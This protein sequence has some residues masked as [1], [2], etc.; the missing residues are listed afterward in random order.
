MRKEQPD[1][2]PMKSARCPECDSSRLMYTSG[3]LTC[4]NCGHVIGK[5]FNKYGA[6]KTE[7]KG[8]KYDSKYEASVAAELDLR[9]RAGDIKDFE[10]QYRVE[11][12]V[13]R[14]NGSVAFIVRHKVDFRV[15]N[16]DGSYELIEAKGVETTDY[17][18]RRRLL[19][20]L[21]LPEH[22]DYTYTVLKQNVRSPRR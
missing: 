8:R 18:W 9:K 1:L 3:T 16:N 14:S 6:K 7:F 19:E 2:D 12:P 21:W 11:I 10:T 5:R 4:T 20:E 15:W 22:P 13:C 17:K